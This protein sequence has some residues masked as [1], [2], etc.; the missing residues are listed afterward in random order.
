MLETLMINST[1]NSMPNFILGM[2]VIAKKKK[3]KTSLTIADQDGWVT[4][5]R[6]CEEG[7]QSPIN[8]LSSSRYQLLP[9]FNFIGYTNTP[10]SQTITNDGH[11]CEFSLGPTLYW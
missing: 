5:S 11:T 8:L 7:N 6:S 4:D 2:E 9:A 1:K 10:T 3:K